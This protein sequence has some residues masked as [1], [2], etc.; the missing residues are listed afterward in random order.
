[1]T[2]DVE[3]LYRSY[4]P[5]VLRRCRQ[6]LSD[7]ENAAEAMQEVADAVGMSVSGVRKRLRHLKQHVQE[8]EGS[9]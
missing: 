4:G 8:L 7:E 1:L 2:V 9:L 3:A 6:L 5:M